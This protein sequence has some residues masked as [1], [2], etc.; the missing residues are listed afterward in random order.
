ME[1]ARFAK[2]SHTLIMV[3]ITITIISCN[4]SRTDS[5]QQWI[6]SDSIARAKMDSLEALLDS[7]MPRGAD[8]LFNDFFFNFASNK[9]LQKERMTLDNS[10]WTYNTFFMEQGFYTP[11]FDNEYQ[12]VL[13]NDTNVTKAIVEKI[14]LKLN[15]IKQYTFHQIKGYWMLTDIDTMKISESPNG[16][17]LHFYYKFANDSKFQIQSLNDPV[18][19]IGPDPDNDFDNLEGEIQPE[20][21][22][23]FCPNLP[24]DYLYNI[25]YDD[26]N[27]S[28]SNK[29]IFVING[30]ANGL[31]IR[32]SF[33][34]DIKKH[35]KLTKFEQ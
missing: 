34:R 27:G 4:G 7:T 31:E 24:K 6:D 22:S 30:I 32:L 3:V 16:D 15:S 29:K 20:T 17:F 14:F 35:W 33:E 9:R 18:K 26:K 25:I 10:R 8:E 23:A 2:L 19:F 28:D 21:W 13:Q 1:H 5:N 12:L 11:I